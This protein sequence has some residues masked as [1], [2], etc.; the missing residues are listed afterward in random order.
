MVTEIARIRAQP[1]KA[2][3]LG[4]GL[5]KGVEVIRTAPGCQTVTAFRGVEDDQLFML[6]IEWESLAAHME[7]FR[8]SPLF[9]EYRSHINGM[10]VDPIELMHFQT[11]P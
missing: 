8:N 3:E 4:H 11:L 5:L 9:A 7:G 2:D 10:F 6:R 1:G